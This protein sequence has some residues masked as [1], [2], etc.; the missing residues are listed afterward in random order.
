MKKYKLTEEEQ[1][2]LDYFEQDSF[3]KKAT[4][5]EVEKEKNITK[6]AVANFFKKSEKIKLINN[7][8]I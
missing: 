2:I 8:F 7:F 4:S 1:E 3:V 5:A 6:I